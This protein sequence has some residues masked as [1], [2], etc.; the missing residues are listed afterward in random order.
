MGSEMCIRDSVN[1]DDRETRKANLRHRF[2]TIMDEIG[3]DELLVPEQE[4]VRASDST[5][6]KIL[7]VCKNEE[8]KE[9]MSFLLSRLKV[10]VSFRF[11]DAYSSAE[12]FDFI[13][14]ANHRIQELTKPE[15]EEELNLLDGE[16]IQRMK[17]YLARSNRYIIHY[18]EY[19]YLSLIHI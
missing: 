6:P 15:D 3:R 18:G 5:L 8:D 10:K 13:I 11:S 19:I 2:L 9:D 7:V 14:Y 17:V 4:V 1:R 16:H 12:R